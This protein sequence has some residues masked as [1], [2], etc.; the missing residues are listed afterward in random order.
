MTVLLASNNDHKFKEVVGIVESIASPVR[1]VRPVDLGFRFSCEETGTTFGENAAIKARAVWAL[2]HGLLIEGVTVE[3]DAGSVNATILER[4]GSPL[5]V[6]SD[7]SGISVE[8]L[9]GGPGVRSARYGTDQLG[10]EATDAD[11][12]ALLLRTLANEADRRAHY[13]CN[14]ILAFAD[15]RFYQ[16]QETWYGTITDREIHG[17]SGFGYDPVFWLE[18]YSC[19]VSQL[20]QAQK[21]RISH[22]AKAVAAVLRA[23]GAA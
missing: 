7:D 2:Q 3:P 19:S 1:V 17:E 14:A 22:R 4:F 15:D 21:D 18:E 5:P 13:T 9:G 10:Q 8:A 20:P 11:R 6:L 23:A 12:T 16:A